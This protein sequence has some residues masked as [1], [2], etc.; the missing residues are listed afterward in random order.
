MAAQT[1]V[2]HLLEGGDPGV[3]L[4]LSA[5]LF[6]FYSEAILISVLLLL[7]SAPEVLHVQ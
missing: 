2:V 5:K 3:S 1:L 4:R 7:L 6:L